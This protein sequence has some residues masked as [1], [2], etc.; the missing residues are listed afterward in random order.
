VKLVNDLVKLYPGQLGPKAVELTLRL[1]MSLEQLRA[2]S[3]LD[4]RVVLLD[5]RSVPNPVSDKPDYL[6]VITD[7][8]LLYIVQVV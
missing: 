2:F 6:R 4:R 1:I 3:S 7:L 5:L 8:I